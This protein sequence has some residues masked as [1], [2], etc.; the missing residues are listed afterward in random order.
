MIKPKCDKC[1]QEL[2]TFGALAFSPPEEIEKDN[3]DNTVNKYHLC[4]ACWQLFLDW[5]KV[6]DERK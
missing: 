4:P 3:Y 2:K 6:S 5:L 1:G